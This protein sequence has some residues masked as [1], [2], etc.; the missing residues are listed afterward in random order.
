MK[1][2]T[3]CTM[4]ILFLIIP[5]YLVSQVAF[6]QD[7][8]TKKFKEVYPAT[9]NTLLQLNNKYGNIDIRDWDKNEISVEVTIVLENVSIQRAEQIFDKV[10]I[11]FSTDGD[12]ISVETNYDEEFFRMVNKDQFLQEKKFEVNYLVMMPANVKTETMNKYGNI[13]INK[14]ASASTIQLKYGTLKINQILAKD[15]DNMALIDL[16]Y[17][18]GTIEDCEWL[19]LLTKYSQLSIEKSK[20]LIIISKYSKLNI[21]KGSSLIC[22]SKY[23]SYDIGELVN[24]VTDAQ[25]SNFHFEE[26]TRKIDLETKYTDIKVMKVPAGF[27]SIDIEN[28]YGSIR[29]YIDPSAS[30]T[31]KGHAKYAKINYPDNNRVNRIQENS[32]LSVEGTVGKTGTGSG[33]VRIET[34]YGGITLQQ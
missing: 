33:K 22:E 14:L 26:I 15:K 28:S 23:D 8:Q 1:T 17:S 13:F 2:I 20:A 19:K 24:F 16:A 11:D 18:K 34:K 21:E 6:C 29:I 30:Y 31:L 9:K 7:K 27:E 4:R 12:V 3:T 10:N 32:E 25:Y 5:L